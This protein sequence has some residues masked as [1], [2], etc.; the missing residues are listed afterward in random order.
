MLPEISLARKTDDSAAAKIAV[1][2][3]HRETRQ[4]VWQSGLSVTRSTAYGRWIFGAG[5]FQS[6]SIYDSPQ[7]AGGEILDS[8]PLRKKAP[9]ELSKEDAAYR[10]AAIW[11]EQIRDKLL[12][13]EIQHLA[14]LP[15]EP[16]PPPATP[17]PKPAAEAAEQ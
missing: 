9:V 5:P 8:S 14:S 13:G 1:F 6:G 12:S 11:D 7:F 15:E 3:Y 2:A 4:P 17:P 16:S 10:S